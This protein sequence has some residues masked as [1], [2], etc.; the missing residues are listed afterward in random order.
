MAD[1]VNLRKWRAARARAEAEA[2]AAANRAAYGRTRA[3]KARDAEE[4]ARRNALLDQA[5]R[6]TDPARE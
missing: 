2:K 6:E 3:Q 5:R 1:V 4:D